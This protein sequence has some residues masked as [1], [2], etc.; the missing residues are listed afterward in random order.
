MAFHVNGS[1][2]PLGI[3]GNMDRIPM[4]SYFLFKDLIT[5]FVFI[6]AFSLIIFFAP[7]S[8]GHP[9]NYIPGNPMVTPPSINIIIIIIIYYYILYIIYVYINI[10]ITEILSINEDNYTKENIINLLDNKINPV[11][12]DYDSQEIRFILNGLFQAKGHV[13]GYFNNKININ[14]NPILFISLNVSKDSIKLFK[15]MNQEFNHQLK[16]QIIKLNSGK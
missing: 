13:D 15:I 12:Y 8:M 16:Y 3:S 10:Y 9:D 2:N 4:H 11:N 5:A 6:L 14:F 1:S 7:N